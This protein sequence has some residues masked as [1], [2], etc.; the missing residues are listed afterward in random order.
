MQDYVAFPDQRQ[1][2]ILQHLDEYGAVNCSA[3][4]VEMNVSEHTIRRDLKEL[5]KNGLCK[6]VHG[7]AVKIIRQDE[8]FDVRVST[9]S[10]IKRALSSKV[11]SLIRKN[12]CLF[13]D[14]GSTNLEI[15]RA[16]PED[17]AL[18]VVTNSPLIAT[19]TDK[20]PGCEVILLGGKLYSRVGGCLGITTLDQLST[21]H[22]DQTILG[23]CAFDITHGLTA[24]IYE[25]AE[26]KRQVVKRSNEI[27][28]PLNMEKASG[29]AKYVV[30]ASDEISTLVIPQATPRELQ[31]RLEGGGLNVVI[32]A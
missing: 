15:A 23:V 26:F 9:I 17:F 31:E 10:S 14:S 21:F 1:N 12:A 3:L 30:A 22:F 5:E 28:I 6:K 20:N 2:V 8:G 7:G 19:E 25:D 11:V 32:S 29:V 16:L 27:I 18:T 4:S 13:L 24:F